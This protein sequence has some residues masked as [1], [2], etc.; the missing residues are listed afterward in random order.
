MIEGR[1][2]VYISKKSIQWDGLYPWE[3]TLFANSDNY[4]QWEIFLFQFQFLIAYSIKT[5]KMR[6]NKRISL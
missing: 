6:L 1:K 5:Y 4:L 2:V 3:M